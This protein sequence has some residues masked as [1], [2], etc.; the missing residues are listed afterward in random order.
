MLIAA[1]A[2]ADIVYLKTGNTYEGTVVS[3]T[4][5][6]V[7]IDV[8]GRHVTVP[9]EEVLHIRFE[10]PVP[11]DDEKKPQTAPA[12]AGVPDDRESLDGLAERPFAPDKATRPE[13]IAFMLMRKLATM[14]PGPDAYQLRKQ[15]DQWRIYAHDRKR[16]GGLQWV[17]PK[18]FAAQCAAYADLLKE[19]QGLA[20]A[21]TR[22]RQGGG[23]GQVSAKEWA[24]AM[25]KLKDAAMKWPDPLLRDFLL[26]LAALQAKEYNVAADRFR[27]C[28]EAA[29]RVG[30][31]R[32]GYGL[33]QTAL[34]QHIAAVS[35]FTAVLRLQPGSRDAIELLQ[36]AMKKTPGAMTKDPA[37]VAAQELL[38]EY[39]RPPEGQSS[40]YR[41]RQ[42]WLM[43]GRPWYVQE[44]SLLPSP[45]C[46]R[47][48]FRQGVAVPID[49]ETLMLDAAV[50]KDAEEVFIRVN[51]Q[52]VVGARIK[53]PSYMGPQVKA[54]ALAFVRAEGVEFTPL[55]FDK[56]VRPGKGQDVT[57]YGLSLYEEMGEAVRQ[58]RTMV[59]SVD[60]D[61]A[62]KL[63]A[64]AIAGEAAGPVVTADG[65]LLGFV[66]DKTDVKADGGGQGLAMPPAE[67]AD[68][69]G[70]IGSGSS[71][72]RAYGRVGRKAAAEPLIAKGRAFVVYATALEKL[73]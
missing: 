4:D 71:Y 1:Q 69:I 49:K 23:R 51:S 46:D 10:K 37:F 25:N 38:N 54:G 55:K 21:A 14:P 22:A 40:Y 30:G 29:P 72:Y 39:E 70:R 8:R 5:K 45:P 26:G 11:A 56:A 15:I 2:P 43:P 3:R 60:K 41:R 47:L 53:K 62:F 33:A 9:M 42:V 32:Q 44:R 61:G 7:V 6:E 66:A 12:P 57:F 36:E 50:V 18:E 20:T 48:V 17:S 31:F 24:G 68:L 65:R 34:R 59:K 73:E 16:R 52:T 58:V 27:S 13:S 19:A 63:G 67:T 64:G 35:E 28:S